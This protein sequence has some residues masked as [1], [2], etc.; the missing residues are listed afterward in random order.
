MASYNRPNAGP[1]RPLIQ[2]PQSSTP[3]PSPYAHPS[4]LGH[5]IAGALSGVRLPGQQPGAYPSP[6]GAGY[7]PAPPPLGGLPSRLG[8]QHQFSA[9][10]PQAQAGYPYPPA[11]NLYGHGAY[12]YPPPPAP[13]GTFPGQAYPAQQYQQYAQP[14]QPQPYSAQTQLHHSLPSN[15]MRNGQGPA[16]STSQLPRLTP[17]GYAISPTYTQPT[18]PVSNQNGNKPSAPRPPK[19]KE[20]GRGIVALPNP[21]KAKAVG[22][23]GGGG[24]GGGPQVVNCQVEGC[25]FSGGKRAVREHEEDRHLVYQPGREPKAWSGSYEPVNG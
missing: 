17:D 4:A 23:G 19:Q 21:P 6:P 14:P 5:S 20:Y 1:S 11:P 10:Y 3:Q 2:R 22:G 13:A 12:P 9:G 8:Q 7:W 18:P 16:A 25:T 24:G 15:P